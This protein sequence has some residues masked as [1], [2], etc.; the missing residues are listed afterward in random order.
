MINSAQIIAPN[1]QDFSAES[2]LLKLVAGF[3]HV[4][5]IET[6]SVYSLYEVKYHSRNRKPKFR[7]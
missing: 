1:W 3:Y 7:A 6:I 5:K 2:L 4:K